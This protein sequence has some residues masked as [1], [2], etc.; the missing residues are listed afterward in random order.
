MGDKFK[1]ILGWFLIIL[2]VLM[3]I[4]LI[5]YL[6]IIEEDIQEKEVK[7]YDKFSNEIIGQI[8]IEEYNANFDESLLGF[9]FLIAIIFIGG[10]F[11]LGSRSW[12][13]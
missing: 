2:A 9:P 12:V 5:T 10:V 13:I 1:T 11:T 6:A 8:C 3:F 4:G 7:C